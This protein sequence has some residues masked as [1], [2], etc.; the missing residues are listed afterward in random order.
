MSYRLINP[1][2]N[3]DMFSSKENNLNNASTE[4]WD[5]FS[6]HIKGYVPNFYYSIQNT[7]DGSIHHYIAKEKESDGGV[8]YNIE[9]IHN[10]NMDKHNNVLIQQGGY[11]DKKKRHRDNSDSNDN[12]SISSSSSSSDVASFS[13]SSDV[14]SFSYNPK[15]K[16]MKFTYYPAVYGVEDITIPTFMRTL[17]GNSN[18]T[19]KIV[20]PTE[21]TVKL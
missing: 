2:I 17:Y 13:S 12:I 6:S 1:N 8:L 3:N 14:V 4:I 11:H 19:L 21:Y 20:L 7:K 9:K 5:K 10:K 18:P 15:Y 16:P